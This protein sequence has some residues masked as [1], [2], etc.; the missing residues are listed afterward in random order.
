MMVAR[1]DQVTDPRVQADLHL[2]RRGTA[3]FSR[4][5]AELPENELNGDS[6]LPGWTRRHV[7]AD[8]GY[9]ARA[10]T[11]LV[12]GVRTGSPGQM[13]ASPGDRDVEISFGATLPSNAL[14]N[15]H[16]HAAVHLDVEWRD[17]PD[18]RWESPVTDATGRRVPVAETVWMRTREVWVRAVD[19]DN[20]GSFDHLPAEVL[21]RLLADVLTAWP[22]RHDAGFGFTLLPSDRET[23]Y[24]AGTGQGPSLSGT[25]AEIT[26]WA[27]GRGGDGI[28]TAAASQHIPEPTHWL[29]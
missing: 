10:L 14:R 19:L 7:V 1:I 13:Y 2:A 22:D 5:L 25:M 26:R 29:W 9:N 3:Y 28:Q 24:S 6:L 12:E 17:L 20:G 16:A 11:R 21:D 23:K 18:D 15:L 27:L 8:V 4:K